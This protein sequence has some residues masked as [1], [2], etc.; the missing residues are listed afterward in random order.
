MLSQARGRAKPF[1]QGLRA[2]R[3]SSALLPSWPTHFIL[4]SLTV[5]ESQAEKGCY[6]LSTSCMFCTTPNDEL[7]LTDKNREAV[8]AL[9]PEKKWQIYCSKKKVTPF[10]TPLPAASRGHSQGQ[11]LM[12]GRNNRQKQKKKRLGVTCPSLVSSLSSFLF[13][14]K[15]AVGVLPVALPT[16]A[17]ARL[18]WV[19]P[20]SA[21]QR[22][23]LRLCSPSVHLLLS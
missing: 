5:N 7:D 17:S 9:P 3:R 2:T 11:L 16:K 18:H 1:S 6:L 12:C 23:L 21:S 10:L 14:F 8:F 15:E 20:L 4:G 13:S 22:S 19:S